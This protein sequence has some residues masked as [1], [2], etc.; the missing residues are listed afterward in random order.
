VLLLVAFSLPAWSGPL[1]GLRTALAV[2]AAVP[3]GLL[4]LRSDRVRTWLLCRFRHAPFLRQHSLQLGDAMGALAVLLAPRRVGGLL[5]L[6]ALAWGAEGAGLW[7]VCRE[8]QL[9][10]TG[11]EALFV[12]GT[13]TLAGSLSFLPGGLGGTEA[14][15]IGLLS[16]LGVSAAAGFTVAFVVRLATL[17]LAVVIGGAVWVAG[18]RQLLD[19]RTTNRRVAASITAEGL[20]EQICGADGADGSEDER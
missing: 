2:A 12:Y 8:L 15:F 5:V 19:A 17:W 3:V 13:G 9:P 1:V 20:E 6:S 10:V 18:R 16:A 4:V 11:A 7:L 14:V